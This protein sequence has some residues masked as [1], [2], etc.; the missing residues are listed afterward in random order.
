MLDPHTAHLGVSF[1]THFTI[2]WKVLLTCDLSVS[3]GMSLSNPG[4]GWW[5]GIR[6]EWNW[7]A[8]REGLIKQLVA[9]GVRIKMEWSVA[10]GLEWN[11]VICSLEGFA[12]FKP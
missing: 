12:H 6:M 9:G 1:V 10:I 11:G 4:G 3:I 7:I 5:G 2:S 8:V